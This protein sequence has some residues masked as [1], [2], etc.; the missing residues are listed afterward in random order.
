FSSSLLPQPPPPRSKPQ[1]AELIAEP[2][3]SSDQR[4]LGN[5]GGA[6]DGGGGGG[7]EPTAPHVNCSHVLAAVRSATR[8]APRLRSAETKRLFPLARSVKAPP[9]MSV[10]VNCSHVPIVGRSATRGAQAARA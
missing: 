1:F 6:P 2:L 9:A 3:N 8:A 10:Q 5:P 4:R 7:C